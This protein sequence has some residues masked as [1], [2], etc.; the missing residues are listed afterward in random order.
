[1]CLRVTSLLA[2]A[3][4]AFAAGVPHGS[5]LYRLRGGSSLKKPPTKA[6]VKCLKDMRKQEEQLIKSMQ[7]DEREKRKI[8][9]KGGDKEAW[10]RVKE[11]IH[12]KRE[13][14]KDFEH[15]I[16]DTEKDYDKI[17]E[18]TEQLLNW[19]TR[20]ANN[21]DNKDKEYQALDRF[22]IKLRTQFRSPTRG[23]REEAGRV[24][25]AIGAKGVGGL[26]LVS[27]F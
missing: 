18:N 14:Q 10:H 26:L 13:G 20:E 27:I 16:R 8:E 5:A 1:M 7:D 17:V 24:I 19:V 6:V 4:L 15:H 22:A 25:D 11:Q 12:E 3:T 2:V 23:G 21:L 9:E